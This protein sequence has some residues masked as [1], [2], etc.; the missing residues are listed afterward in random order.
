MRF[1][2]NLAVLTCCLGLGLTAL[3]Q[4]DASKPQQPNDN[5]I[6]G[7]NGEE[8]DQPV[9]IPVSN[10]T[11]AQITDTAWQMLE[12][13]ATN[14]KDSKQQ[15]RIDALNALGTLKGIQRA[16]TD[17]QAA[18]KD[19]NVDVRVAAVVA[20]GT[21]DDEN[22]LPILRQSLDDPAP[23]VVFAAAVALWKM[24]DPSG[25]N[26]L[27]E[28]LAGE[29]KTKGSFAETGKRQANQDLHSPSTLARIGAQQG[30]YALLGPFGI[31]LDAARLMMKSNN[32][33]SARLLTVNLLAQDHSDATRDEFIA[34][35]SDKDYIVRAGSARVLGEFHGKEVTD[36]LA[37]IFGDSKP[38]VRFMAAASYI[39]SSQ[40]VPVQPPPSQPEKKTP[41][42]HKKTTAPSGD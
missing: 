35:L 34:A 11:P 25:I 17:L 16:E 39:R 2:R 3:A 12:T 30:A 26:I 40:P 36:A 29:R 14:S 22:M 28:V 21:M 31:G 1:Y 23:E 9:S 27:Y 33:N 24:H 41:P 19:P 6:V 5:G 13:S 20:S 7:D 10:Q 4:T 15:M 37:G 42:H 32:G 8:A 18:I 38:S